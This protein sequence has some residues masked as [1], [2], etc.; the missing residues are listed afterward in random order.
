M[1][2]IIVD[3]CKGIRIYDLILGIL[4]EIERTDTQTIMRIRKLLGVRIFKCTVNNFSFLP[5]KVNSY[6]N[7]S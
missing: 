1:G 3:E 4:E 6:R 7:L 5:Y 2:K